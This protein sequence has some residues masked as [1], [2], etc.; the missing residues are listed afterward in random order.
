MRITLTILGDE[1][2]YDMIDEDTDRTTLQCS[3]VNILVDVICLT[4]EQ[5]RPR[6]YVI[7]SIYKQII[8]RLNYVQERVI[9]EDPDFPAHSRRLVRASAVVDEYTTYKTVYCKRRSMTNYELNS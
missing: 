1:C 2:R 5:Q 6:I 8:V 4:A 7:N 9:N 3:L